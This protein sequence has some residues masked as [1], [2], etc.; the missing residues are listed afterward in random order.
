MHDQLLLA[1]EMLVVL[2]REPT[3]LP[4]QITNHFLNRESSFFLW[5]SLVNPNL[6]GMVVLIQPT[7]ISCIINIVFP[8]SVESR[9]D[10]QKSYQHCF[11]CLWKVPCGCFSRSQ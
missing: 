2:W 6:K 3:I 7:V 10:A 11:R 4:I 1:R 5:S 8:P 9:P